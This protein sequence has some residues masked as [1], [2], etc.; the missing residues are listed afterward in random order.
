MIKQ[1]VKILGGGPSAK[2]LIGKLQGPV[3]GINQA[4]F[5]QQC[6]WAFWVDRSWYTKNSKALHSL[7]IP[8]WTTREMYPPGVNTLPVQVSNSGAGAIHLAMHLGFTEIYLVG[9]DMECLNGEPNWHS[10]YNRTTHSPKWYRDTWGADFQRIAD[11]AK[12][13]E[14][15]IWNLNPHSKLTLFPYLVSL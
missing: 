11:V 15:K 12:E 1:P 13:K 9:F 4:P 8:L 6:D 2:P 10:D 3:I 5:Y 7:G 14:I